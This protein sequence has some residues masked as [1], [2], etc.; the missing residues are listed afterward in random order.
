MIAS[1]RG[2]SQWDEAG[3]DHRNHLSPA[4]LDILQQ[5]RPAALHPA[6]SCRIG[7]G[8]ISLQ[9]GKPGWLDA[10]VYYDV[11]A[12]IAAGSGSF[13][14]SLRGEVMDGYHALRA[15]LG[16]SR[17]LA[18]W[19]DAGLRFNYQRTLA[20]GHQPGSGLQLDAGMI[21]TMG[22]QLMADLCV[23][24]ISL[25]REDFP[26]SYKPPLAIRSGFGYRVSEL[27]GFGVGLLT[28]P[29]R[30]ST[31]QVHLA[32]RVHERI[33]AQLAYHMGTNGFSLGLGFLG[34]RLQYRI[35][36][37]YMFPLGMEG[38][39]EGQ[40]RWGVEDFSGENRKER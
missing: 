16:Y 9:I 6:A 37:A 34:R 7:G 3:R 8:G 26:F 27:V 19:M 29:G 28:V 20:V 1:L 33:N 30:Q 36:F 5:L 13:T 23:F 4:L 31:L 15:G 25:F 40:Y 12:I 35:N 39:V 38:S 10:P 11:H 2:L 22:K 17:K 14:P 18:G 32:Y 21:W 24:N